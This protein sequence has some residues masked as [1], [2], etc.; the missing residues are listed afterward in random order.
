MDFTAFDARGAAETPR[1]Y[2]LRHQITGEP[3]MDGDKP[4]RVLVR[5]ASSRT[6]QELIRQ[7]ARD[8]MK[9]KKADTTTPQDLQDQ[10][11]KAAARLIV[12][13]EN[14]SR[15]DKPATVDDVAWFL[16]LTMV[17]LSH[18]RRATEWHRP[19]FGQQV[20]DFA[21]DD[22]GFLGNGSTG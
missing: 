5:G 6:V 10:I 2:H 22:A 18:S 3:I 13:F 11:N 9:A 8:E 19:S 12:G 7:Q 14:I 17:S 16:D 4:C 21:T 20:V 1:P 15:G